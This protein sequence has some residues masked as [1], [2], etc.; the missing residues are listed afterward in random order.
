M[1]ELQELHH[2]MRAQV[3]A[4]CAMVAISRAG[5]AAT[6]E[7]SRRLQLATLRTRLPADQTCG[8]VA[9]ERLDGRFA[10]HPPAVLDDLKM[11]VSKLLSNAYRGGGGDVEL[12][13]REGFRYFH[14][15]VIDQGST[16]RLERHQFRSQLGII[17]QLTSNWGSCQ[18]GNHLW[19][20]VRH[21]GTE[22]PRPGESLS[23]PRR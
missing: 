6:R 2:L 17:G 5:A 23:A 12:R 16:L 4:T 3:S 8:S 9:R 14:V 7:R 20:H 13:V 1:A 21:Q 19:A 11:V 10:H 18:G 15:D 22:P